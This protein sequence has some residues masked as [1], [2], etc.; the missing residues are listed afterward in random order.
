ML[1]RCHAQL[2][3]ERVVQMI[4]YRSF[5]DDAMLNGEHEHQHAMFALRLATHIAAFWSMPT[6]MTAW[7]GATWQFQRMV[8]AIEAL[9]LCNLLFV[10][11]GHGIQE[12]V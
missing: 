6:M 11:I 1:L 5:R 9:A 12:I 10:S 2:V 7:E 8:A 4:T 3:V